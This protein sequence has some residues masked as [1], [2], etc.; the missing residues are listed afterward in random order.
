L[1]RYT[2]RAAP[3]GAAQVLGGNAE[4]GGNGINRYK[5]KIIAAVQQGKGL[6]APLP[7]FLP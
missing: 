7:F 2:K 4:T 6:Y 5:Q 1:F 3:K